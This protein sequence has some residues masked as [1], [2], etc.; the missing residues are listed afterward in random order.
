MRR[1]QM[2]RTDS[3]QSRWLAELAQFAPEA[4]GLSRWDVPASVRARVGR[5]SVSDYVEEVP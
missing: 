5:H 4:S 1:T 2:D 3:R